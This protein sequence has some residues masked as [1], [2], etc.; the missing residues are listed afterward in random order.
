MKL[1]NLR[2]AIVTHEYFKGSGQELRDY[3]IS[4][5]I[6]RLF[7]IAHQFFYAKDTKSYLDH[8]E[9]GKKVRHWGSIPLPKVEFLLY[10]RD[11]IYTFGYIL[12]APY[13]FDLYV[14]VDSFNALAGLLLKKLGK[15]D[16]VVFFTI[17]YVMHDRFPWDFLNKLYVKMDR[18]AFFGADYTWNVSDR[19]SRQ[20][21]LEI[22]DS[23]KQKLQLVVPIGVPHDDAKL[24]KGIKRKDN[25]LVYSGGLTPQFGLEL[26]VEAMPKLIQDFPDLELRIIGE[27]VIGSKLRKMTAG[28]DIEEHVN[29]VGFI[30]TA[31][32]RKRWLSLLKEST[33][34]LATYEDNET[35]YKRFSDVTK[36]KDYMSVGLPIITTSVIPLS[37]DV[38]EH[39]LGRVVEYNV[40]SFVENIAELLKNSGE[41]KKIESNV[42]SF[43]KD[44]TWENIFNRVL[45]E[46]KIEV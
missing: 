36:P 2:V 7:Y 19:M 37:E 6:K 18:W 24:V 38:K 12:V 45:S 42:A 33:L 30:N 13:K 4:K 15:V 40:E 22:G 20:R 27:G 44:M 23:A 39:N 11:I 14:G 3:F 31:K 41:R 17:D 25:I 21:V 35:T 8:Y 43:C 9:T 34:G 10:I 28:L 26:M 16:K 1:D 5:K 32:E 29:F 46:M